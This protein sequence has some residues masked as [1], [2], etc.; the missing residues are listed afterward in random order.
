MRIL[1]R[2]ARQ[3]LGCEV[4]AIISVASVFLVVALLAVM[5]LT[6][7]AQTQPQV[8]TVCALPATCDFTSPEAAVNDPGI[9]DGDTI[10]I[11]TDTYVL[12]STLQVDQQITILGND[13][14]FDAN[15]L[16]A[17]NVTGAN[18]NL[19]LTN[20]TIRDA[21]ANPGSGGGALWVSGG[22]TV[23]VIGGIFENNQAEFGGALHNS[24]STVTLR[25][26]VLTGNRA[27]AGNGGAV[28]TNNGGITYVVN[29]TVNGNTASVAGG[30]LAVV[31]TDS[32][33]NFIASTISHNT[34]LI[35]E[36]T[37]SN[38]VLS[39]TTVDCGTGD[40]GP[41]G[42]TFVADAPAISAFEFDIRLNGP[43]GDLNVIPNDLS[44]TGQLRQGG[45][46]GPVIATAH[47]FAPGG[48]WPGSSD[49]TLTF[50]LDQV[51]AL[52]PGDTYLIETFFEDGYSIYI[53]PGNDY[54]NGSLIGCT[55]LVSAG[56]DFVFRTHGGT[57]GE[58]S[59]I[60][61]S[62]AG[63]AGLFNSTLSG[64]VGDGALATF[65]GTVTT[66]FSTIANNSGNGLT[67]WFGNAAGNI[68]ITASIIADSGGNDCNGINFTSS[69]YNLV[70]DDTNCFFTSL[71]TDMIGTGSAP[72]DALLEPLQT[73][74]GWT[75]THAIDLGSPALDGAGVVAE[76]EPCAD[77]NDDQRGI[78][79]PDGPY[80]PVC[81]I[82]AFELA[83]TSPLQ[84]L[85]DAAAPGATVNVADGIYNK[86][87]TI[88]DGKILQGSGPDNVVLDVTGYGRSAITALGDFTLQGIR[89]TGGNS[90]GNG[91]GIAAS[92]AGTD[93]TLNNV[94][95]D[96]N[97]AVLDGGAI[98]L[99]NGTLAGT[100]TTFNNNNASGDGGAI[101]SGTAATIAGSSFILNSA[102]GNGGA[103]A[104]FG[105]LT[106]D[107]NNYQTNNADSGGA[108]SVEG[109]PTFFANSINDTFTGNMATRDGG[110]IFESDSNLNVSRGIL[111][112]N[113]A[114]DSDGGY[115]GDGGA[116]YSD[117]STVIGESV[118]SANSAFEG[119]GVPGQGGSVF[120][121]GSLT[122]IDSTI[123]NSS[124]GMGGGLYNNSESSVAISG[125]T[126]HN[127]NAIESGTAGGAIGGAG[128]IEIVN[129]TLSGNFTNGDGN[130]GGIGLFGGSA[131]LNNVT[132]AFNA[133]D[134]LGGPFYAETGALISV[135]NSLF[136]D[137]SGGGTNCNSFESM[138]YNLF[139]SALCPPQASDLTAEP[140]IEFLAS[141]GGPTQTH[142][143]EDLSPAINAGHPVPAFPQF[144]AGNFGQLQSQ[145][146]TDLDAG[147]LFLAGGVFNVGS[148]FVA[149]PI[150]PGQDFSAQ[151][152]FEIVPDI[153]GAS[154]G[155]TF[156]ISNDPTDLGQAGGFLGIGASDPTEP[157]PAVI[158]VVTGVSVEFDTWL[159]GQAEGANDPDLDHIGIDINGSLSS[160]VLT[161]VGPHGT[162][163][164]GNVWTA[165]I[166][167]DSVSNLLEVRAS[168]NGIRPA[169]P[170]VSSIVDLESLTGPVA[171]VGFTGATGSI[172]ISG[173]Q[174]ILSFS[175]SNS[176]Q[177]DD[178]RGV[179]RPVGSGCDIGAF[180]RAPIPL[181]LGP[182]VLSTATPGEELNDGT[183][184]PGVVYVPIIDIPIEKLTGDTFNAP[185]S[186]PL[187]SFPIGSFPIGSFNL[188]DAPLGSFP[189]GSFPIGSFPLGSFPLGSFPLSSIPLL[190]EGGWK[191]ILEDIPELTGAP[192]QTVTLEQVL[193]LNPLPDSVA[194][195]RLRDMAI[196]GSSL[197][198]L[199]LPSLS[200]GDTT[201]AELD[202]WARNAG[203]SG[204]ICSTLNT[205]DPAFSECNNA[206]TL[207]GLEVKGAPVSALSLSSL[208]LG[209]FPIGSFPLGSFPIGSFPL[210]SFPIGSF[211][212]GSF[213]I[214]SFPIGSFPL[215]SFPLG[216]FPLG[217]FNLLAAPIGSFPLGSFPLGSF[218]L[219]S[220]EIDGK[221]FCEFYDEQALADG[222]ETCAEL[223]V[224]PATD[225]LA[226]LVEVLQSTYPSDDISSTPL[227]SFPMG[228]FPIGSF[229]LGSFD[230]ATL[231]TPPI[232]E[233]TLAGIDGCTVIAENSTD[234]C[235]SLGL[236]NDST[237]TDAANAYGGSLATTPL[238]SF[239]IGS[240][241]VASLPMGSFPIG[242]F[243][244][245]GAPLG[246]F[247][248]GS[249][250]LITSPLGSFPLGSFPLGS[251]D[252]LIDDP[253][254]LCTPCE[255]LADAAR[256]G[257]IRDTAT[258]ADLQA[259]SEYDDT[260]LGE[261]LNAMS[262][263]I[264][265]GPGT[266]ADIED[267]GNL[268]LGQ[269][270]IAMMLKTD[271]PWETIPLD[272]LDAQAF[273]ADNYV[274]YNLDIPLTGTNSDTFSIEVT[275]ADSFLYL[276]GSTL[277]YV[278][279]PSSPVTSAPVN[280]PVI[281]DNVD[282][283]QT[284]SFSLVL[285]GF[286]SNR[287]TFTTVPSMSLGT[288]PASATVILG[289]ND[290]VTANASTGTVNI[291]SDPVTDISDPDLAITIP[292]NILSLGH[293]NTRDDKDFYLVAPPAGGDRV[294][295]FM[296]NPAGDNDL[297]MYEPLSTVEAKG[298]DAQ[299]APLDSLPFE[300]DGVDYEGN[301]SEEPNALED[302]NLE[303]SPL[304]SISTN[305]GEIGEQVSAI[306]GNTQ[307]FTIQI[308][309]YNGAISDQPYTLRVKVTPKVPSPQ[310]TARSWPDELVSTIEPAGNWMPDTNAVF[311][312]NYARLAASDP[313]G[314]TAA[315]EALAAINRLINAPGIT[316]G[317]VV[318]VSTIYG[319]DYSTW[320]ANPCDVDA[321]NSIVNAITG[322][323]EDQRLIS[324]RLTYVTI[325]GSDEVIPFARK[326]DETSIA[327]ESTF[328]GEFADNAMFGALVTRHFLSDDTYGD[329]DP[330]PWLDR[331]LNVPELG[332]GRLVESAE[333]IRIAAENYISFGG[334]LDPQTA[335]SAGYDFVADA[336]ED[337]D[338]T[339]NSY[340]SELG[341]SVEP[342]LIDPPGIMPETDAWTK[343]DFLDATGL[344]TPHPVDMVS[345]NMHFD[346]DEA[347]PS[348][349]D[350]TG[351][352]EDNLIHVDDLDGARVAG[353][354]WFTVGCHSGTNVA[355]VSVV[356]G[357]PSG[358]WAQTF[359][360]LGALYLA[361]NAYGLGDTEALA[362]TERLMA[363]F[364]ANLTGSMSIG[365]AHAFAKQ[366]YFAGLGLYGE[367]DYKALQAA[368]LFGLPMYR[369][370]NGATV[371][372][373][374]L[375]P[376]PITTDPIS[377]LDS[378]SWSLPDTGI[379]RKNTSKGDLFSVDGNVQF[380]HFRPLQP[381][382]NRDVT[383]PSG[384]PASGAFL[385]ALTTED[386]EVTDIAFA[387]PVID[388]G[389]NEPEIETAEVVFPASFTNV[390]NY[391]APPLD[392]G[393][394]EP[395]DQLNVIVGQYTSTLDK[396][397]KPK[398]RLFRGFDAQVFYRPAT[399]TPTTTD[400]LRPEFDNVQ[401]SIVEAGGAKQSAFSVDVS[402][403]GTVLRVAVLYLQSVTEGKGN[404]VLVD[405]VAGAGN[406][407][408]TGGGPVEESAIS[409]GNTDYMVQAIDDNGNVANS[410]FK[411][412]FYLAGIVPG[413]PDGSDPEDPIEVKLIDPTAIPP[414]E[415]DT[416]EWH[417]VESI[418][419]NIKVKGDI[420]YEYSVDGSR[421]LLALTPA[422]FVVSGDGVHIVDLFGS[423]GSKETFALLI[424]NTP[425]EISISAPAD[426]SYVVQGLAPPADYACRDSGSGAADCS[427]DVAVG[428]AVPDGSPGQQTFS[429]NATDN[430]GLESELTNS[431]YVV[432][433]L[434]IAGPA[435]PVSLGNVLNVTATA[436]DLADIDEYAIVNWGDGTISTSTLAAPD[437]VTQSGDLFMASHVYVEP[438]VYPV[439]VTIE[440]DGGAHVQTTV[441]EFAVIYDP[442]GGFVTEGFVTGAGWIDSPPGAYT[443]ADTIDPDVT[444][445]A[446][447][448]FQS[449]Y[450]KGKSAPES[451]TSFSFAAG[452]LE[453]RATSNDWLTI[454]GASAR[455]RGEG[456]IKGSN[457]LY[458]VEVIALDADLN[459]DKTGRDAVRF[460][461]WQEMANGTET[462]LYDNGLGA[463]H[464][465]GDA[466][467]TLLGGGNIRVHDANRK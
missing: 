157:F 280:D 260:T 187:G 461:I 368:T 173:E 323:L 246:S 16:P 282:G 357:A 285:G 325:V 160:T 345:F 248:L 312:V 418:Q 176:C 129:S 93:I 210:G 421:P 88:G 453:F 350:A 68:F 60:F 135:S 388:L 287:I 414:E 356:G 294:A 199:S 361:Q 358:D 263:A 86:P 327:N 200:L 46:G 223:G 429:V 408:W 467:T 192:L 42:Q 398:E 346:F 267:T 136:S 55:G 141:N 255:T 428:V 407:T 384:K 435:E 201:V 391:K 450:K 298:Q 257:V 240:F 284:L 371:D 22:A 108:I 238:G 465:E 378:A 3:G 195:V 10:D 113:T 337:I 251:F 399:P 211:P 329:I 216:S 360:H 197:A 24:G 191:E 434:V 128:S 233:L 262:L 374:Q 314:V 376:L 41:M 272:Q 237:L 395:R 133:A 26:S 377:G 119:D 214:G 155:F 458:Q 137:N 406:N 243:E 309:G 409:N 8:Y 103:I 306:A 105:S 32:Q 381:I 332:V 438:G 401:A 283:T 232:S 1:Y 293:I 158:G 455:F 175:F 131:R 448:N 419:V 386:I 37:V 258:F 171:Y 9:L 39:G 97:Q 121:N 95:L 67:A 43:P 90:A 134:G 162:L 18:T 413:A 183:S 273:S 29:T 168:N 205:A 166:D 447:F 373:Q 415:L 245:N 331:Y 423:D 394:F 253:D 302:V 303:N 73:N 82:G 380:V 362:L 30:G 321:P 291:I 31:D 457:Q 196:D 403:D 328:A 206:D 145:G 71:P 151:F 153:S 286:S 354:I 36:Q 445:K 56:S 34:T 78:A 132:L 221:S 249:F 208:P 449:K 219:G 420:S 359:G 266:L 185:E 269:L 437:L 138:G 432:Q 115:A 174:R 264:L 215:G 259:S 25:E 290:P 404:W 261:V 91:G 172:G 122:L 28:L 439:T 392:G 188:Q 178:Q 80:G 19:S 123:E 20:I 443:P 202:E 412:L 347:L 365:Q 372:G 100:N 410:T 204:E 244:V 274:D 289:S 84:I 75:A 180:E 52:V 295:V 220:F 396:E 227:G 364:A 140:L 94:V 149:N 190:S 433:Q 74:G 146:F 27:T 379:T 47:A 308:S 425:A 250:E 110:A 5:P 189:L 417:Q 59:G 454:S 462:V 2:L 101:F 51:V 389:E 203:T 7:F 311:L 76:G 114:G 164:D 456:T 64:N 96:N 65:G 301:L 252:I 66:L 353:G 179:L 72:I 427:G 12:G 226:D 400:F 230:L 213:P 152:Q 130:G 339:F 452:K 296:S 177:P 167:Y 92:I 402:D 4:S 340:G 21:R 276:E 446:H 77:A 324:P 277:L 319:V 440:Y 315:D 405:L 231:S 236:S 40:P 112:S 426:G 375:P 279:A 35:P 322:Y 143:L 224:N 228:S 124:A 147:T 385:T 342:A 99:F 367:Y 317:V 382:V 127:N 304:A 234:T 142:A 318:D 369:Y 393:P 235:S 275:I 125:T 333:D 139:Q 297:L 334:V 352:Y 57:P 341:Y 69:G 184:Y 442:K 241:D 320:D 463:G 355:D 281:V 169:P 366:Q 299:S 436:T 6:A 344:D 14:V 193:T 292:A 326:P 212:L 44:L 239:P 338:D 104:V 330:I 87:I 79:R 58:G 218:P 256:A 268:T 300:D 48:L 288:Y 159:N 144:D 265:Y 98:Y 45:P 460:R 416:D 464:N 209:S 430:T 310:C 316:H 348:I 156:T 54:P 85:I 118:F 81:D 305:R 383:N 63:F 70:G 106:S 424:D 370:G 335:L 161:A 170:T 307:P 23:T 431:Y 343:Q 229:P 15:G 411:G 148:A 49:Q 387:R 62:A 61:S 182:V 11:F 53:S 466:G 390:A 194:T 198:S 89:V 17:I 278:E 459:N 247:P 254:G 107:N 441:F 33:L 83:V 13:S 313:G 120:N 207:L 351:N 111:Q 38:L 451:T 181:E 422:G 222:T 154:D 50:T 109:G 349:G 444:G 363:N 126:F 397:I 225:S 150:D 186:A 165:W 217:S 336:A 271:F 117:R 102:A 116:I 163:S 270:L 242:S